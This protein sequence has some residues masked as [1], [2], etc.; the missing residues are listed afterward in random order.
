MGE[1]GFIMLLW[2]KTQSRQNNLKSRN[3]DDSSLIAQEYLKIL[4]LLVRSCSKRKSN[5]DSGEEERRKGKGK[6]HKFIH[7]YIHIHI[8][9]HTYT[10]D[11]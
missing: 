1:K 6:R 3:A 7:I 11:S 10:F 5:W 2:E 9:I 4:A 8:H